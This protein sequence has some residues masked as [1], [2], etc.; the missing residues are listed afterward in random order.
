[1]PGGASIIMKEK[2]T[3]ANIISLA[4]PFLSSL[5]AQSLGGGT[6]LINLWPGALPLSM[7]HRGFQLQLGYT[8]GEIKVCTWLG[9]ISSC[10]CLTVLPGPAW[11]LLSKKQTSVERQRPS[12]Y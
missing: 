1:M 11:L 2:L 9:E 10:S 5:S 7:P 12:S 6:T 4:R 3:E 8:E